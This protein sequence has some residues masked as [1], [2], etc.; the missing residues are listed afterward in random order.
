MSGAFR[1][2]APPFR[3]TPIS[4]ELWNQPRYW[5][6]PSIYMSAGQARSFCG[7]EY[8]KVAGTGIEPDVEN[9][10]LFAERRAAAFR[11]GAAAP[12]SSSRLFSNTRRRRCA[13]GTVATTP[14]STRL[15][16]KGSLQP[17]NRRRDGHAP[18]AL[19]RD[20]PVGPHGDHV[21]HAFF[22]P[23]GCH[24]YGANRLERVGSKAS[25]SMPINHCSVARKMTG[26]WQRQQCGIAMFDL[27]ACSSSA[28]FIRGADPTIGF[29]SQ[30]VLPSR[31]F[32]QLS[33]CAFRLK[34][35][36]AASTGQ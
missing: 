22:A 9:I 18:D 2:G 10:G 5:S 36:P 35:W 28:P 16:V 15:S 31:L 21:R 13:R 34:D 12:I 32:R 29:A 30:T 1:Y 19:P 33:V 11:A 3:P 8:R 7:G 20:A 14:S 23:G 17:R 26:L 25:R 24:L 27:C 4:S 6:P